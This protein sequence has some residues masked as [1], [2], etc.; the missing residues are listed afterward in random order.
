M[1]G[2]AAVA[3]LVLVN[4]PATAGTSLNYEIAPLDYLTWDKGTTFSNKTVRA[5]RQMGDGIDKS[6]LMMGAPV[7]KEIVSATIKHDGNLT[8]QVFSLSH[9]VG[10]EP[11]HAG[12]RKRHT[13]PRKK[14]FP[15][16]RVSKRRFSNF[17][18]AFVSSRI[19]IWCTGI[20]QITPNESLYVVC[21]RS[22]NVGHRDLKWNSFYQTTK[23][24]YVTSNRNGNLDPWPLIGLQHTN[25]VY[26]SG[27]SSACCRSTSLQREPLEIRYI[28]QPFRIRCLIFGIIRE[29]SSYCLL[30]PRCPIQFGLKSN[31]PFSLLRA[32]SGVSEL[33]PDHVELAVSYQRPTTS[34]NSSDRGESDHNPLRSFYTPWKPIALLL[35]AFGAAF[36]SILAFVCSVASDV[37]Y[38]HLL[39]VGLGISAIVLGNIAFLALRQVVAS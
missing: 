39:R 31:Q 20:R 36:L 19:N 22:S 38:N 33:L 1:S 3:A 29:A 18:A 30:K 15:S 23:R 17:G 2:M 21:G 16:R 25:L 28:A 6:R 26:T 5:A 14:Y 11:N 7:S 13:V 8:T 32:A 10:Q 9:V 27:G 37:D 34:S 12:V 24:I 35:L 4:T